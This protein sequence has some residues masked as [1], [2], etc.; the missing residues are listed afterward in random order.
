MLKEEW[1]YAALEACLIF[2]V[3][4]RFLANTFSKAALICALNIR[5]N[6]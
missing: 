5:D 6:F 3:A 4:V 1:S 2:R